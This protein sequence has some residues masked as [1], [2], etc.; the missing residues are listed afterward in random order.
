MSNNQVTDAQGLPVVVQAA[1]QDKGKSGIV[2]YKFVEDYA[3]NYFSVD[4]VTGELVTSYVSC[5]T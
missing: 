4:S 3:S 1:D 2:R 5:L